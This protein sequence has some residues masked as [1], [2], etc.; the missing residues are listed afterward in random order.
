MSV[1]E[2]GDV[3]EEV[4]G[5]VSAGVV[6]ISAW[7]PRRGPRMTVMCWPG[8]SGGGVGSVGRGWWRVV[9]GWRWLGR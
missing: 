3:V 9:V 6:R 2:V 4:V 1:V 7:R 8:V 5:V